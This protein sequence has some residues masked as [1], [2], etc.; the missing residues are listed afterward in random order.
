LVF[1]VFCSEE[2]GFSEGIMQGLKFDRQIFTPAAEAQ[3]AQAPKAMGVDTARPGPRTR[4]LVGYKVF[5]QAS[6]SN[7]I[8]SAN[9]QVEATS[10]TAC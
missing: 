4:G 8:A 9:A 3:R 10:A 7:A 1:F 6:Q 5:T 2:I